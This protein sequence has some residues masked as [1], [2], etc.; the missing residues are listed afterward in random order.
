MNL[1]TETIEALKEN[2]QTPEQVMWCGTDDFWFTWEEFVALANKEYDDGFG[3][4][5]VDFNLL[6]VGKDWWLE[7]HEYDGSEWWEY[8]QTPVKPGQRDVP[9]NIFTWGLLW[10][11][12]ER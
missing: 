6:V 4:P 2:G 11:K 3:A 5:E 7:R 1:L 9:K 12:S 8:K 10:E